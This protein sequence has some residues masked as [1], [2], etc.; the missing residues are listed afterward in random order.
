MPVLPG[1][2]A[3]LV[4][5]SSSMGAKLSGKSD[6]TRMDAA[7][8]LGA[9]LHGD[10]RLFTFSDSLIEV[11]PRR[12][13]AGVD[14]IKRS[15]S[16]GGTELF[17]AVAKVNAKVNYDRIIVITDEQAAGGVQFGYHFGS[18]VRALQD[19][20]GKARG[21]MINVAS[22]Q[23]GVGYGRWHHIDG[24]SENVVRWIHEVE[25]ERS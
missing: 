24:F 10:I 3:V 23:R 2:S 11:P 22:A 14:A 25:Q 6:M 19:P 21:Y 18:R 13:M 7:A 17:E 20:V 8:A 4:D 15:Q 16:H 1:K 9:I 5:V 12:G